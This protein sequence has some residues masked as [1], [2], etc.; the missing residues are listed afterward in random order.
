MRARGVLNLKHRT[1]VPRH[2]APRLGAMADPFERDSLTQFSDLGLAEPILH[3]LTREGYTT[4]TPIQTQVVP[5]MMAGQDILG[6]AQTGT[7]K[8]AAFVLPVL[9]ALAAEKGD[10][11][12]A[13]VARPA[14]STKVLVVVPTRELAQQ[15][16]VAVKT[17]GRHLN[18]NVAV[19]VGGNSIAVQSRAMQRGVDVLVA[20]PGRLEDH[21]RSGTVQLGHT[22]TIIL[23]E[24]DQMLDMGFIPAIRRI[25]AA[26]P[27]TRQTVLLS[28]TMPKPLAALARDFLDQPEQISVAPQ[29]RPI[30]RIEQRVLHIKAPAKREK[31]LELLSPLEVERAIVFTR[32][33]HGA[34]KVAKFLKSYGLMSAVIHGNRS[35][36]QREQALK[37]FKRGDVKVMIATDVAARGIDIP[38]VSHVINF[39]LPNIPEAY[40]HRI[41]R[42]ARAGKSGIAISLVDPAENKHLRSIE[43]LIKQS[44]F[45]ESAMDTGKA[46]NSSRPNAGEAA[47][48]DGQP[49]KRKGRKE[50]EAAKRRGLQTADPAITDVGSQGMAAEHVAPA[51][52]PASDRVTSNPTA[53]APQACE[54]DNARASQVPS[55]PLAK[56]K[57]NKNRKPDDFGFD[58]LNTEDV[59]KLGRRMKRQDRPRAAKPGDD[60][61]GP[62]KWFNTKKGYGF[63]GQDN[64]G[65]DVFVHITA[66]EKAGLKSVDE[67][68]RLQ[69]E[70]AEEKRGKLSAINL[71]AA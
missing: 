27:S 18:P 33:K 11:Q 20:T 1:R 45:A 57:V 55:Q 59:A 42:T 30:D 9:H 5:A 29:A 19:V 51:R 25:M 21:M 23:D 52:A 22:S 10:T 15:I 37:Q 13:M 61:T 2:A 70:L 58:P 31:L 16:A 6:I 39:E 64:G 53:P 43:R 8:T 66:M 67:G 47:R 54:Q 49:K 3:A 65:P 50:R 7:G 26:V 32:T 28:A 34:D 44:I 12:K 4:P 24:A 17:Y 38:D 69:Y 62:L 68:Q 46:D 48:P 40:V 71:R 60:V 41:G 36:G 14:K 35:Q 56:R 63:L